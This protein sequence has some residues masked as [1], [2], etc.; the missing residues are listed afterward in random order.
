MALACV[1]MNEYKK[2]WQWLIKSLIASVVPVSTFWMDYKVW[3][4]KEATV[5]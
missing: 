5:G 2:N 4:K 1:A 3:K